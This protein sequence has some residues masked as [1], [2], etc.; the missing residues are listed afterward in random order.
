MRFV[1]SK[2]L[3]KAYTFILEIVITL[4]LLYLNIKTEFKGFE[5]MDKLQFDYCFVPIIVF[6][7]YVGINSIVFIK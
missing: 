1:A 5:L 2:I 7:M 6:A 4:G 3:V